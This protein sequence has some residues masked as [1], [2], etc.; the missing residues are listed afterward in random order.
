MN[1]KYIRDFIKNTKELAASQ[2]LIALIL[3]IQ[4]AIVSRGLGTDGYGKAVLITSLAAI[5]FRS[6]HARNSDVTILLLKQNG[7]KV[8]INSMLFDF[9]IGLFGFLISSLFRI[10]RPSKIQAGFFIPLYNFL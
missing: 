1:S 9:L 10:L 8:L 4:V 2:F 7:K 3:L 5:V 6:L